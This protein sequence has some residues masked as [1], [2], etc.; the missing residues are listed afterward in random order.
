MRDRIRHL[1]ARCVRIAPP[2]LN[3]PMKITTD[4]VAEMREIELGI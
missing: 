3:S 4:A 1:A 2:P